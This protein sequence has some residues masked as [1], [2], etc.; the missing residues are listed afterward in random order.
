[1]EE[2]P[3]QKEQCYHKLNAIESF[4]AEEQTDQVHILEGL[5]SSVGDG[6]EGDQTGKQDQLATVGIIQRQRGS[7]IEER[8]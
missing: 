4:S 8:V 2:G 7:N 6:L 3:R 1:M 5:L